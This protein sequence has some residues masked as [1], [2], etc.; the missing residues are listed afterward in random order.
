[1]ELDSLYKMK[2]YVCKKGFFV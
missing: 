2:T 1:M